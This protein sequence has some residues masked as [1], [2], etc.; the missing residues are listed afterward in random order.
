MGMMEFVHGYRTVIYDFLSDTYDALTGVGM[1]S[2][3]HVKE[4]C[5]LEFI[6]IVKPGSGGIG[7]YSNDR[8]RYLDPETNE[9]LV[10]ATDFI[11]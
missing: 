2:G 3:A 9:L 5:L 1:F 8:Q 11:G 10:H 7:N 4:D 6:R